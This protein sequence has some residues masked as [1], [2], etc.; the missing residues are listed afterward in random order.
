MWQI[1]FY[2]NN[3]GERPVQ[4]FIHKLSPKPRSKVI[5]LVR[6]L[7]EFGTFLKMPYAKKITKNIYELRI[8][9]KEE[10]RIF[11]AISHRNIYLLHAFKKKSQEIPLKEIKLAENRFAAIDK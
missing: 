1:L 3:R 7:K 8:R 2:A 4:E 11:Y 10:V 5:A 6:L 9:G